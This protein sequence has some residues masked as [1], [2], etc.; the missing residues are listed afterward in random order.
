MAPEQRDL[1][2]EAIRRDEKLLIRWLTKK[3]GD[4]DAARDVAQSVFMR[5]WAYA[6]TSVLCRGCRLDHAYVDC[7]KA[8]RK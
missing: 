3:L 7:S 8:H 6:E 5:V 4:S 2:E 1:I